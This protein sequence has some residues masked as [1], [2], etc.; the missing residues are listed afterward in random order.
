[1]ILLISSIKFLETTIMMKMIYFI[2]V[3]LMNL[4]RMNILKM[5]IAIKKIIFII[6]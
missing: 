6:Q 3:E 4:K 1:M 5:N 2:A